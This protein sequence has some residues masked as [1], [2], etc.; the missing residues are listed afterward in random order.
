MDDVAAR[1]VPV[2][3]EVEEEI[4]SSPSKVMYSDRFFPCTI[5]LFHSA[6]N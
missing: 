5:A 1:E 2:Y 4:V 3:F 6:S